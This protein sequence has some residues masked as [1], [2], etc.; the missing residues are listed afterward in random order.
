V[1]LAAGEVHVW[2]ASL[3]HSPES[4]AGLHALLSQ[5]EQARAARFLAPLAR[6]QFIVARG[7]LR[8]LLGG[9]LG[10][11]PRDLVFTHGPQGK[12]RLDEP[13]ALPFNVSHSHGVALFAVTDRAE[14]G[15]DVERIRTVSDEMLLAE[16]FFSS[17]EGGMLRAL[18]PEARRERFFHLWTRK[19]AFLK[20]HGSGLSYGLERVEITL[21]P[22]DAR[23]LRIDGSEER[24]ATW[25]LRAL[26]PAPGY[27]GAVALQT[28]D[29]SLRCRQ[30]VRDEA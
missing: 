20:A 16:R 17:W 11:D 10:Q 4:I 6:R 29:Y 2:C 23:I 15:V 8:T 19:E 7:L 9:Y 27:V 25:S 13:S 22:E 21:E 12:P 5:E 1:Q 14:I 18:P 24:A 26:A 28:H 30:W 3:E